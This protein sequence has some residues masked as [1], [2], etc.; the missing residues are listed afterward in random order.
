MIK[1]TIGLSCGTLH[2]CYYSDNFY[3]WTGQRYLINNTTGY[4]DDG[5]YWYAPDTG[6]WTIG[7]NE[8]N[9]NGYL[10]CEDP[11]AVGNKV[12][13]IKTEKTDS[14]SISVDVMC[15]YSPEGM[16]S[17]VGVVYS[18]ETTNKTAQLNSAGNIITPGG[19]CEDDI[20]YTKWHNLTIEP[21]SAIYVDGEEYEL[22]S[23]SISAVSGLGDVYMGL[24]R[25]YCR[26]NYKNF[27]VF[28][29]APSNENNTWFK[30]H[31][32]DYSLSG[33]AISSTQ[34]IPG[35]V[36][37]SVSV[38]GSEP[39][40]RT[41]RGVVF[42]NIDNYANGQ[43]VIRDGYGYADEITCRAVHDMLYNY[44]VN[45]TP[46]YINT[47]VFRTCGLISKVNF[48]KMNAKN[49]NMAEFSID[50][51]ETNVCGMGTGT[52]I[53]RVGHAVVGVSNVV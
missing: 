46:V 5:S 18:N 29:G 48:P 28:D 7:D 26:A 49:N 12:I 4:A 43:T 13:Y 40:T 24:T 47:P 38:S 45:G 21:S 3:R 27:V 23:D 2:R 19:Y 15:Y 53:A 50:L 52:G 32:T 11:L 20:D 33:G 8:G 30:F 51:I 9:M 35:R 42:Q 41:I 10:K 39:C 22:S 37:G 17:S 16:S 1:N 31:V 34:K 14:K 44:M 25:N 36:G 6:T